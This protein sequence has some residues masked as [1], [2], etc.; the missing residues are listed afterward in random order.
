MRQFKIKKRS[1]GYRSIY[2]PSVL[3]GAV[4]RETLKNV[5]SP[6]NNK[7]PYAHGFVN[8]RSIVSNAIEHVSFSCT[9]S[10]DISDFF[11]SVTPSLL[12]KAFFEYD[13]VNTDN[14]FP[15][16]SARQGLPTSPALANI[17]FSKYDNRIVN[18]LKTVFDDNFA[19]TRYADDI[20]IS[21]NDINSH[22][23]IRMVVI[24]PVM[25]IIDDSP[26]SVNQRKTKIQNAKGGRREV[27]GVYVDNNGIHVN[28]RT[29]KR[30]RALE[31]KHSLGLLSNSQTNQLKGLR[32]FTM[33]KLPKK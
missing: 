13:I 3:E 8:G 12:K 14:M 26:F 21:F 24:S 11:D 27:C 18:H 10:M 16:G 4:L 25:E 1:G 15:D 2:A 17:A 9:V 30:L 5:L 31:H 20:S 23:L 32:E 28:R 6:I 7:L 33:L 29:R 22:A 19:Y